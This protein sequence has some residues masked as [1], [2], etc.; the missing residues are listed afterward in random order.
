MGTKSIEN[1]TM[2]ID[3]IIPTP[4]AKPSVT[5]A[6][7]WIPSLYFGQGIPYVVVMTLSVIMYKNMGISNADIGLYTSWLYLPFVIKPLWSPLVDLFKSK[8]Y[9]IVCMELLIGS[10]LGLM[11]L[12]IPMAGFFRATLLIFWLISF[13]AAT[14]DISVDGFYMLAL[15]QHQQAAFAGVRSMFYRIAMLAGQGGLVYLA[16][17]LKD[18]TGHTEFGWCAVFAVLAVLFLGLA[19]FHRAVLPHPSEDS[20]HA[21]QGHTLTDFLS[22]FSTFFKKKNLAWSI[23]FLLFYRF[24]EAQLIKMA[25]PFL[26]DPVAVGGLGLSTQ[27]VGIIYG[28]GGM[29]ALTAGGLLGGAVIS[30][31]GL[32]ACI[33]PMALA[34]NVPHLVYVYLA[35]VQPQHLLLVGAAVVVEQMGY[36]FGFAAYILYMIMFVDGEHK[37]AHYA[38]CTGFMALSMM[39]PGMFSGSLQTVL[40]YAHFFIWICLSA[41]PTFVV[42]AFLKIDPAFGRKKL[43]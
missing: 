12:V 26:L 14:H 2:S 30:R 33:W 40:G 9:W 39:I 34:I 43:V 42:T 29:L 25:Q 16:G 3:A 41:I 15:E 20:N 22:V 5:T 1:Y 6:W 18:I 35:L 21:T 24:G 28:T 36:G 19:A 31:F 38:I 37:T 17:S 11:V 32:K 23:A 10:L 27:A 4:S 13:S 8:R 7:R